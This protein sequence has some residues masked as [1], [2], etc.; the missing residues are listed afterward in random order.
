MITAPLSSSRAHKAVLILLS[1]AYLSG[2]IGLQLPPFRDLFLQL[3][4]L[5][6]LVSV[7]VLLWFHT[8]WRPA[9]VLYL[10]L[11]VGVGYGVEVLGVKTGLVFGHYS[12]GPGL[13]PRLFGVPPVIGLNWLMLTYCFGSVCDRLPLPN[14]VKAL[15]V[16]TAMVALDV[17]VEPVAI[18]LDFWSW[19][20]Q[21][22]PLQNYV[23]WWLLSFGL[24][25]IWYRLP[26]QKNNPLAGWL[27]VLQ[28]AFFLLH[29]LLFLLH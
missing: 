25:L 13:G 18:S 26:F 27:L 14:L 4:P 5:N 7:A 29:S 2:V 19:F 8:D 24:A 21:P 28:Y 15:V 11:A 16:A 3:T 20:G 10:L 9:F 23:G 1:L 12:Y 22:V 6:L 17:F